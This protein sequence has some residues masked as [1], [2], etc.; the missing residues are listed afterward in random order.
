M[1]LLLYDG[2]AT[3]DRKR[4]GRD[5]AVQLARVQ[6]DE[7]GLFLLELPNVTTW[8][9]DRQPA[10]WEELVAHSSVS[11]RAVGDERA[12]RGHLLVTN[13]AWRADAGRG[14]SP[15]GEDDEA[16][17][18]LPKVGRRVTLFNQK[19]V[20]SVRPETSRGLPVHSWFMLGPAPPA[21]CPI[22]GSSGPMTLGR[23]TTAL[24]RA[25]PRCPFSSTTPIRWT[26]ASR[27]FLPRILLRQQTV[28]TR[29][30]LAQQHQTT[31]G[32]PS[33]RRQW[34]PR[35]PS[36]K[37]LSSR[38][39]TTI[40]DRGGTLSADAALGRSPTTCPAIRSGRVPVP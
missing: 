39:C 17:P 34:C 37:P 23:A 18:T 30:R 27:R 24:L 13:S 11:V 19:P 26:S 6:V 3:E 8:P 16:A 4:T 14:A 28:P 12:G 5:F 21:S 22:L 31:L 25:L 29:R 33:Q 35:S 2:V 15:S 38:S 20:S 10:G 36:P 1:N 9:P 40:R 7:G 32:S